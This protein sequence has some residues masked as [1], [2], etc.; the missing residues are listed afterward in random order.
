MGRVVLQY[1]GE[2]L[3]R[4]N[5][6]A[7]NGE[8][9]TLVLM[10]YTAP[11][12]SRR[13]ARYC[14]SQ[15]REFELNCTF[16][17]VGKLSLASMLGDGFSFYLKIRRCTD[18]G[19]ALAPTSRVALHNL[20]MTVDATVNGDEKCGAG[21]DRLL[22]VPPSHQFQSQARKKFQLGSLESR[23][24]HLFQA[25]SASDP[26]VVM[27]VSLHTLRCISAEVRSSYCG[28]MITC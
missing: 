19:C 25:T 27:V 13:G 28:A 6:S 15:P 26:F 18:A 8:L 2:S 9:L 11:A 17:V 22:Y 3:P 14:S 20:Q 16:C 1:S 7:G 10:S 4:R 12:T 5:R 23:F 21:W 24:L